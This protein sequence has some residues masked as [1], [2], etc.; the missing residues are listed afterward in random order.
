MELLN[1]FSLLFT[2]ACV[3]LALFISQNLSKNLPPGPWKLPLLGNIHQFVG[4]LPHQTLRNLA[5]QFGP[6]MHLQLGE[7]S[8][9]IVSSADI[10]KQVMKTHDAIFANR[11]HLLASKFF[12][13]G[14]CDIAFSPYGKTWRQLKKICISELLN[15]KHVQSLRHIREEEVAKLVR[16]MCAKEGSIVN[17]TKEIESVTN[18]IIARAADGKRCKDQETF[19]SSMAQMLQLLGGFSIA[20]FYPSIKILPFLTGMK[21]KLGRAQREIDQI[22]ENM[23][24]DHKENKNSHREMQED[25]IDILLKTHNREIPLTLNNIKAV[26]WVKDM[27]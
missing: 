18:A 2:F 11:P 21:S 24:K 13:Y 15:A 9:I 17:L 7:K 8:H 27:P 6:L 25:F 26:I 12:D 16:N 3:F 23:V 14:G 1:P 19:I 5:N 10:A 4:A 22:L 20:D